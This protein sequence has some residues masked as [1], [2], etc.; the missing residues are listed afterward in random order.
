MENDFVKVKRMLDDLGYDEVNLFTKAAREYRV[1]I[2]EID[3]E[4]VVN[5]GMDG[6]AHFY[7]KGDGDFLNM[8]VLA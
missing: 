4:I 8:W 1:Y 3:R 6:N 7:F 2:G 5:G